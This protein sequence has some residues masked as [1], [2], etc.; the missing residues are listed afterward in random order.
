MSNPVEGEHEEATEPASP[1]TGPL[2]A[3]QAPP[4]A[5]VSDAAVSDAID[6]ATALAD[7][8][9]LTESDVADAVIPDAVIP[10]AVIPALDLPEPEIPEP[11]LPASALAEPVIPPAPASDAV[12]AAT[13]FSGGSGVT[14][15]DSTELAAPAT[16]AERRAL[17]SVDSLPEPAPIPRDPAVVPP[18]SGATMGGYRGWTI[19]IF[20]ILIV[21]LIAAVATV[22]VLATSGANPFPTAAAA[23]G[24]IPL[25]V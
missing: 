7:A 16:R 13:D 21:L 2:D 6:E 18:V 9:P 4:E 3:G 5:A 8:A 10:D 15:S 24:W 19:A 1:E 20:L 22:I 12:D 23:V 17:P 14:A 25:V 11:V